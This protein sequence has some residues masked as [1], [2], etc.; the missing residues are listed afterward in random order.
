MSPIT[1]PIYSSGTVTVTFMIGSK[2]TGSAFLIADLNA[3]EPAILNAISEE[4]TSWY[5]PSYNVTFTSTT[6]Y[7]ASIPDSIAPCI[8]WSTAGIYSL[9]I[10][11]PTIE[12]TNS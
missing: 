3:I 1:S 5:E 2:S 11:P 12:L 9:G 6:L 7:P 4:S 8:P 10:A